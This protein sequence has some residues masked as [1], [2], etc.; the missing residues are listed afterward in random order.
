MSKGLGLLLTAILALAGAPSSALA[1]SGDVASTQSYVKANYALVQSAR[2][3]LGAAEAALQTVL[4]QVRDE[5]PNVAANSPQNA[6]STQL[7]YEVIGTMVTAAIRT[8]V[9]AAVKFT[10]AVGSLRWSN[11]KLTSTIQSYAGKVKAMSTLAPPNICADVRA[12]VVSDYQTLP[13]STVQFDQ[14]FEPNWVAIGDLP[15]SLTPYER[16]DQGVVLHRSN[17]LE[18]D[19]TEFE[20]KAVE[21][22]TQIMNTLV[23]QP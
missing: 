16:P 19:L 1:G 5:C 7:S 15:A 14:V 10:R 20:A 22:Y 21:T 9:P 18:A 2:A 8:D 6:D 12:W 11:H 23:V 13:A 4:R 17:Q 3:H